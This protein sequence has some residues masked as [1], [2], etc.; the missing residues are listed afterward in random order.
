MTQWLLFK[1]YMLILDSIWELIEALIPSVRDPEKTYERKP[2][3]GRKRTPDRVLF[4]TII[5]SLITGIQWNAIYPDKEGYLCRGKTAHK[6][7]MIWGRNNFFEKIFKLILKLYDTHCGLNIQWVSIDGTMYKAP[8]ACEVVGKNPTDRGKNGTKRSL[9]VD[10]KGI[11]LSMVHQGANVHD[12]KILEPTL[13]L[14]KD[15]I[16]EGIEVHVCLDAGYTGYEELVKSFGFIPHIRPRGEE[17]KQKEKDSNYISRRWV[18]EVAHAH[19]NN[20]RRL[21][22]RYEKLGCSHEALSYLAAELMSLRTIFRSELGEDSIWYNKNATR[23][24]EPKRN[25]PINL[26]KYAD[27]GKELVRESIENNLLNNLINAA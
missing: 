15:I 4:N 11:V 13:K 5:F 16:P 7:L 10:E 20:F 6:W 9:C 14:L 24:G 3:G 17:K 2:G 23:K 8:L 19:M 25:R 26:E 18:V 22:I 1:E 21:K 12:C 27:L